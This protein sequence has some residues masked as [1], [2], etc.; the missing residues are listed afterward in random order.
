MTLG[1]FVKCF[2]GSAASLPLKMMLGGQW[3]VTVLKSFYLTCLQRTENSVFLSCEPNKR[4]VASVGRGPTTTTRLSCNVATERPL[5]RAA[6]VSIAENRDDHQEEHESHHQGPA[7][8][9]EGPWGCLGQKEKEN[10]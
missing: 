1:H 8:G 7:R 5:G 2:I 3:I 10:G 4:V 9:R 6:G